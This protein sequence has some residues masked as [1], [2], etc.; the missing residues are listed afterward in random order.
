MCVWQYTLRGQTW[1][2]LCQRFKFLILLSISPYSYCTVFLFPTSFCWLEHTGLV[3]TKFNLL[4]WTYWMSKTWILGKTSP[5]QELVIML[6]VFTDIMYFWTW[7]VSLIIGH[8]PTGPDLRAN[9]SRTR[10]T[11]LSQFEKRPS[12]DGQLP[13]N[14]FASWSC[15][16]RSSTV[17]NNKGLPKILKDIKY[18][19]FRLTGFMRR[20]MRRFLKGVPKQRTAKRQME[21]YPE[22]KRWK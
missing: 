21:K 9:T 3:P 6:N 18:T 8:P 14:F 20:E 1:L 16:Y 5:L 17:G 10:R 12:S 15:C 11:A 7:P 22:W 2:T 19:T 13:S 4:L